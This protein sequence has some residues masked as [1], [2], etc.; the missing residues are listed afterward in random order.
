MTP[1]NNGTT[2]TGSFTAPYVSFKTF[3]NL[4]ERMATEGTPQRI[5]R[6]YLINLPGS[7]QSMLLSALDTFGLIDDAKRPTERMKALIAADPDQLAALI[8]DL[9]RRHYGPALNLGDD[10][11]QAQL[12]EVFTEHFSVSG[13]T[14][15][16]AI[17]F[18]LAAAKFAGITVSKLFKTP[19]ATG[20]SGGGTRTRRRRQTGGGQEDPPPPPPAPTTDPKARYI[21]LLLKK[22]EAEDNLDPDLLNRIERV[23]GV[24]PDAPKASD[25]EAEGGDEA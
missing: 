16:K 19:K 15:R 20:T 9:V 1:D 4:I 25:P 17:A 23:I 8:G 6:S 22:A 14:R 10:A 5:D 24:E 2:T 21:D 11:T 12:E 18:F 13:S 7:T 3:T